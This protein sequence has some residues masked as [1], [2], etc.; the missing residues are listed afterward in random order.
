MATLAATAAPKLSEMSEGTKAEKSRNEIDKIIKQAGQFYQDMADEEGRG[1]FPGQ[2]K[3]NKQVGGGTYDNT[4]ASS[5]GTDDALGFALTHTR[6]ILE[7]LRLYGSGDGW[8]KYNVQP[9]NNW[10]SV[11]GI[12]TQAEA[13][14][15]LEDDIT[16]DDVYAGK[17]VADCPDCSAEWTPLFGDEVLESKFNEPVGGARDYDGADASTSGTNTALSNAQLHHDDILDDLGLRNGDGWQKYSVDPKNDWVSVFGTSNGMASGTEGVSNCAGCSA[18][19]LPLFGDEVL[20]SRFQD[21]H[22]AYTVVAGG[23][24]GNDVFPPVLYVVDVE[25]AVDFNSVLEP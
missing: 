17:G 21:G 8:Q 4:D 15:D 14:A 5:D 20:E 3:F 19:W 1:R 13:D 2:S 9:K 11:F 23:G 24:S 6:L 25:N 22:Y 16:N 18:E 10:V 12:T 7:D